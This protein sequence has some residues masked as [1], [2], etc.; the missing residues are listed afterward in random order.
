MSVR[1]STTTR[2]KARSRLETPDPRPAA[3]RAEIYRFLALAFSD[4]R[5]GSVAL[6]KQDWPVTE[7]ALARL[8]LA[9]TGCA[10]L[11]ALDDTGLRRAHLAVFGHTISKDCPPYGAE[12][13][14]AHIFEKT[15]TLADVTGFYRAFG[16]DLSG[17]VRDRPDHLALELE[18]MEFLCLKQ[19]LAEAPTG[20][21]DHET[22]CRDA[23]HAF[24]ESHLGVWAFSFVHRLTRRPGTGPFAD[25]AELL[26]QF[27]AQ[28]L[29]A[30]GIERHADPFVNE[31]SV[32]HV[33]DNACGTCPAMAAVGSGEGR[34][35]P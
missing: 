24:L 18:F 17:D 15:Q 13:G 27:L 22:L 34:M 32:E 30:M 6:M 8:G 23:Q 33:E 29:A 12:Y 28:E 10:G 3:A 2:S 20:S 1:T 7:A 9:R 35:Q 11:V 21:P 4:P 25:C 14:Q 16:L 26:A 5:P 19:A 31:G